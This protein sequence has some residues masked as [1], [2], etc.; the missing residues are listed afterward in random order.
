V[1]P[2][3]AGPGGAGAVPDGAARR[4]QVWVLRHGATDWSVS[5]RHTGR[6]D[7]PLNAE[8]EAQATA[9][10]RRLAGRTF[11]LVLVSPLA[12]A[13][14][15]CALA[16]YDAGAVVDDDLQEWDYGAWEGVTSAEIH[17]SVPGWTVWTGRCPDGE[18]LADVA[19]RAD[20]V[21]ARALA[22]DGDVALFAHGH[23]LRVLAARW[24]RLDPVEGRRFPL[25]T[26]TINVLGWEHDDPGIRRWNDDA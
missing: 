19:A 8:G 6:T 23:V 25:E 21:I 18:T 4:H 24:C 7:L 26:A 9:L 15:T 13:R 12:R 14:Q 1:T 2:A 22:A 20:R 11:A 16:G 3:G 17:E 5:G 10:G